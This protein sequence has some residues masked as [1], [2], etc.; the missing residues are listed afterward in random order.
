[1]EKKI[2]KVFAAIQMIAAIVTLGA[3]FIWSPVCSGM[4]TLESGAQ[5]H[6]KCLDRKSVV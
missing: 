6:M 4:L 5:V 3:I 1:M 2:F